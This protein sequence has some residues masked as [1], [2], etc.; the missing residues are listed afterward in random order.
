MKK[1]NYLDLLNCM[2]IEP[3]KKA[4]EGRY[5]LFE[6]FAKEL[7]SYFA[8]NNKPDVNEILQGKVIRLGE[9][10]E[11][12]VMEITTLI[13]EDTCQKINEKFGEYGL[14]LSIDKNSSEKDVSIRYTVIINDTKVTEGVTDGLFSD[15]IY[16]EL[17]ESWTKV[18]MDLV[19]P[20]LK[21]AFN[22]ANLLDDESDIWL[23]CFKESAERG[24]ATDELLRYLD[25]VSAASDAS[26]DYSVAKQIVDLYDYYGFYEFR[27][28]IKPEDSLESISEKVAQNFNDANFIRKLIN[29]IEGVE[30]VLE[31]D[32]CLFHKEALALS[33]DYLKKKLEVLENQ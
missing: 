20:E 1:K 19:P 31:E 33:K 22:N 18:A 16:F 21:Q 13:H 14:N 30:K 3:I 15:S 32:Q 5:N 2:N 17:K 28:N 6:I 8:E 12:D 7:G 27:E 23:K 25:N 9:N 24:V 10:F 26:K 11:N 29:E 4:I